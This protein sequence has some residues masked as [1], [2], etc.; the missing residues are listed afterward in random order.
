MRRECVSDTSVRL[1]KYRTEAIA[2]QQGAVR[3]R[4]CRVQLCERVSASR[5]SRSTLSAPAAAACEIACYTTTKTQ[6]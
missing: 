1:M 4:S 5:G 3:C 6:G 2:V